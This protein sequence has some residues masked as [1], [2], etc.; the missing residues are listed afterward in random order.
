MRNKNILFGLFLAYL[1]IGA[2]NSSDPI[3][4]ISEGLGCSKTAELEDY[5][6]FQSVFTTAARETFPIM[7]P[8]A[9]LGG[10]G[11][12]SAFA[13]WSLGSPIYE[14][15]G[16]L[17]DDGEPVGYFNL[18]DC[19]ET[20]D[21]YFEQI[22]QDGQV[23]DAPAAFNAPFDVGFNDNT[24]LTTYNVLCDSQDSQS[25]V[26]TYAKVYAN[27][28]IYFLNTSHNYSTENS[29]GT[30][31]VIQGWYDQ[32]TGDIE[33]G[34]LTG[35]YVIDDSTYQCTGWE[36]VRA[37]VSGNT[38]T[39]EFSLKLIRNGV[40]Y[41]HNIAGYGLSRGEENYFLLKM[42]N[43]SMD[44]AQAKY[45]VIDSETTE[46]ELQALDDN[47]Y[48]TVPSGDTENYNTHLEDITNYIEG[49]LPTAT[50]IQALDLFSF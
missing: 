40:G 19:I 43:D 1:C 46:A 42:A 2:G 24:E 22:Y 14:L 17:K 9:S 4:C 15:Y 28:V 31:G 13:T 44:F 6:D 11:V 47:G 20:M 21:M 37:F 7:G 25:H 16:L 8:L 18:H 33:I 27:D 36:I 5:R 32:G 34:L 12:V 29:S 10:T 38:E 23:L 35:N 30:K 39:H 3:A 49:D 48:A 45:Y 50:A 26:V 41:D